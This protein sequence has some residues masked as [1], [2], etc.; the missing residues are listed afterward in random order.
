MAPEPV[1]VKLDRLSLDPIQKIKNYIKSSS[2]E[3]KSCKES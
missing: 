1:Y 2:L 3:R